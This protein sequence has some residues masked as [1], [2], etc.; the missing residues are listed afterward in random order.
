MQQNSYFWC[1]N[2]KNTFYMKKTFTILA[3]IALVCILGACSKK[4][5]PAPS[6]VLTGFEG[7]WVG[8]YTSN[9]PDSLTF[10]LKAGNLVEGLD[11]TQNLKL[12]GSYTLNG[13]NFGMICFD[14]STHHISYS[15]N[16]KNDSLLGNWSTH[17]IMY[18]GNFY[19]VRKK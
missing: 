15:A 1:Q 13:T 14:G 18:N 6:P 12:T 19:L 17:P 3:A 8:K 16:F 4:D 7:I 5:N 9:S 2:I 11:V 10:T